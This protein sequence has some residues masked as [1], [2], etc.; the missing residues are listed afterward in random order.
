MVEPVI[1]QSLLKTVLQSLILVILAA[2]QQWDRHNILKIRQAMLKINTKLRN[3]FKTMKTYYKSP[4]VF[5]TKWYEW[6]DD[7]IF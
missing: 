6:L 4:L 7:N 2:V 3:D 1:S 5:L